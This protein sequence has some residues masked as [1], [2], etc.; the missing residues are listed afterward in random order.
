MG[1]VLKKSPVEIDHTKKMLK[2][3]FIRGRRKLSDG[4][5]MLGERGETGDGEMVSKEL[6]FRYSKLTFVQAN[7]QAMSLPQVQDILEILNMG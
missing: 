6:S 7:C 3:R 5:G 1:S 2:F 4:G